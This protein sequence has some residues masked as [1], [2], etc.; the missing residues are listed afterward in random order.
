VLT[1]IGEYLFPEYCLGCSKEGEVVCSLCTEILLTLEAPSG[2]GDHRA[3]WWYA[4]AALPALLLKAWKYGYRPQLASFFEPSIESFLKKEEDWFKKIDGVIGVPLHPHRYAE[5]GFNQADQISGLV[6]KVL[7]VPALHA[8]KRVRKT[9]S[10]AKLSKSERQK[11]VSE[12]FALTPNTDVA[13]RTLLVVDD[14]YTTGATMR[15][16]GTVL[17]SGGAKSVLYFTLFKDPLPTPK[18]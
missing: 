2:L 7:Q 4:E 3:L 11:N 6:G 16:V 14:V 13:G 8:V 12:A 9:L 18:V 15:E 5:R 1:T 17:L 10:Q